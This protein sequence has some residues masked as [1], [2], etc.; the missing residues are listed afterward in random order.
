MEKTLIDENK[1]QFDGTALF[2]EALQQM[3]K[4][5][6]EE[7]LSRVRGFIEKEYFTLKEL[8][9]AQREV[10]KLEQSLQKT[11][12]TISKLKTGDISILFQDNKDK[13]ADQHTV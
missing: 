9:K 2:E 11:Q 6:K 4:A 10:E 12:D 13:T 8:A 1:D 5:N 3:L 7:A